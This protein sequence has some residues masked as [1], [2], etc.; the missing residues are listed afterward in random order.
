MEQ[1]LGVAVEGAALSGVITL[2]LIIQCQEE[3]GRLDGIQG[4][5]VHTLAEELQASPSPWNSASR[6]GLRITCLSV[7]SIPAGVIT[8]D[9]CHFGFVSFT[10]F[11]SS[12]DCVSAYRSV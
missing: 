6:E 10:M 7:C 4:R 1:R 9:L 8:C 12:T 11:T 2:R 3:G 5:F